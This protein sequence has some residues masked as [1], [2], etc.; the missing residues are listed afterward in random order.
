MIKVLIISKDFTY[1][2]NIINTI[3]CR[4]NNIQIKYILEN[5]NEAIY[6]VYKKQIDL[7]LIDLSITEQYY[8]K[9]FIKLENLCRDRKIILI[10]IINKSD[11]ELENLYKNI[12]LII[13]KSN[14]NIR[15]K[16]IS[17]VFRNELT[18]LGFNFKYK[19]T[20][21]MLEALMY[22]YRN[23]ID[24]LDNLE[25]CVYKSIAFNKHKTEQN[26]KTNIVKATN[27]SYLYQDKQV[28]KDY[29]FSDLKP[30][31]KVILSTILMKYYDS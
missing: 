23:N 1:C 14:E 18:K 5:I 2:K 28:F 27:L 22:I 10:P 4:F 11:I 21:Y 15:N 7:L 17:S 16:D 9:T 30:T 8:L 13:K 25:K 6:I 26:I 24:L 12:Q 3:L 31:P 20:I 29:F 19:G